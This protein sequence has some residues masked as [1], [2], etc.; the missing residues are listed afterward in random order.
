MTRSAEDVREK[1]LAAKGKLLRSDFDGAI[2][3]ATRAIELNP[4][5]FWAYGTRGA[6]KARKGLR[7]DA[8]ADFGQAI[9]INPEY[10]FGLGMRGYTLIGLGKRKQAVGDIAKAISL[11]PS[12]LPLMDVLKETIE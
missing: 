4:S 2:A 5:N 6:A 12:L 9:K 3:D 7:K 1:E 11:D 10:A 8:L